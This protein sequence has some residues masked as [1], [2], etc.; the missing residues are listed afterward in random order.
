M[1]A[2]YPLDAQGTSNSGDDEQTSD[3]LAVDCEGGSGPAEQAINQ[4]QSSTSQPGTPRT[5]RTT[6]HVR[7]DIPGTSDAPV[8]DTYTSADEAEGWEEQDSFFAERGS[9]PSQSAPLLTAIE[10]PSITAALEVNVNDLLE[11]A[12]PKSGIS[13]AFMNMANSIIGAGIIGRHSL[14]AGVGKKALAQSNVTGQPYAFRQ[15][16]MTTGI[17]LLV[18]LTIV[19]CK[20]KKNM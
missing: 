18:V 5:P 7:F 11:G 15:A 3:P 9:S 1:P 12:R 16:G 10:A 2:S 8:S 17:L 19:V 4:R 20:L 13:S 14:E 6:N